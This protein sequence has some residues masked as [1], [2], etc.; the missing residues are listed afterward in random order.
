MVKII[1]AQMVSTKVLTL[2]AP[3]LY[4]NAIPGAK[5]IFGK[6]QILG[7]KYAKNYLKSIRNG[8]NNPAFPKLK[9]LICHNLVVYRYFP[10]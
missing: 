9:K 8:K 3:Y 4:E 10:Y 1:L 2:S 7:E 5:F 6:T